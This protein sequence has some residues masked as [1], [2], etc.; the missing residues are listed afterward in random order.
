MSVEGLDEVLKNLNR[1][2]AGIED[3]GM[4]GLMAAGLYVQGEAQKLAPVDTGNLRASAYTRK[5]GEAVEI[6]FTAAYAIFVHENLQQKL[7]GEPRRS[8]TK[9]GTYWESGEPKFLEK[10]LRETD[11]ILGII[12]SYAKVAE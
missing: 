9:K 1:E 12:Q 11:K 8:G 2:V 5:A 4:D 6:G 7:K 3:R 10:P